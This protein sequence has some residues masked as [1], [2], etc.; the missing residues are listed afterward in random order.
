MIIS[1]KN[2]FVF[3]KPMKVAGS[4]LEVALS[5]FCGKDDILTGTNHIAENL[6]SEYEYP[7]R[8][9]MISQNLKR[10]AAIEAMRA[11]GNIDKVTKEMIDEGFIVRFLEPRFHMHATPLQVQLSEDIGTS[12]YRQITIIRNPWDMIVS[13]FWWS[14]YTL[15]NGYVDKNGNVYKKDQA[16]RLSPAR[17][18]DISPT[19]NDSISELRLKFEIFCQM[20]ADM[21]GPYGLEKNVKVVDWFINRNL[22]Y[23]ADSIDHILRFESIQDDYNALC[24]DLSLDS[25]PLPRLKTSQ[26][27]LKTPYRE[28]FNDWTYNYIESRVSQWKEKFK[29]S[30]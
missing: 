29:Y 2:R 27:K 19:E 16:Y 8:N 12:S 22:E 18:P 28:Y 10:D 21:I 11:S 23:Y 4:S 15:P 24:K 1:H 14:F 20:S 6:S 5:R 30:F 7:A 13:F 17:N 25:S 26:R 9:N 3:F